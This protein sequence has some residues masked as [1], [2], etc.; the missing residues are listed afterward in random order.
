MIRIHEEP[1]L[2]AARTPPGRGLR[3]GG[4]AVRQRLLADRALRVALARA[5]PGRSA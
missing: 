1:P 5:T 4:A 3:A 2:R